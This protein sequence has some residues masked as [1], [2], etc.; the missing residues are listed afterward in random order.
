MLRKLT[1][2]KDT[3][4]KDVVVTA[5]AARRKDW[6]GLMLEEMVFYLGRN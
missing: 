6:M 2:R 1:E 4:V 5:T 3:E